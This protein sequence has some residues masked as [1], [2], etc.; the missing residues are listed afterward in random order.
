MS[1]LLPQPWNPLFIIIILKV[2][3][4]WQFSMFCCSTSECRSHLHITLYLMTEA[5]WFLSQYNNRHIDRAYSPCVCVKERER[6]CCCCCDWGGDTVSVMCC[7]HVNRLDA[8]LADSVTHAPS[9]LTQAYAFLFN[10]TDGC[11][12]AGACAEYRICT[13]TYPAIWTR[14]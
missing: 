13:D 11:V 2:P 3:P 12:K 1:T 4:I 7:Q 14:I 8:S 6:G 9:V 5:H 10:L